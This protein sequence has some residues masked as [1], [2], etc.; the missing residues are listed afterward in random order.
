MSRRQ[1]L[2]VIAGAFAV[3]VFAAW[4]KGQDTSMHAW[5][6]QLRSHLGNLSAPW[7]LIAFFAG[8]RSTGTKRG[9]A[10]GLV[11]T[12]LAL[13]GFYVFT[14]FVI[15]LGTQSYVGDL[16][17]ELIA[18]QIYIEG[19]LVTGPLFGALGGWWVQRRPWPMTYVVAAVLIGEPL[20]LAIIGLFGTSVV[21][22]SLPLF[23]RAIPGWGLSFHDSKVRL[24]VYGVELTVGLALFVRSRNATRSR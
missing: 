3:G 15:D 24:A 20:V 12:V 2:L 16:R 13:L 8:T 22:G 19:G 11:A 14:T 1:L 4:A 6:A 21:S 10:Y 17:K 23:I 5:P 7:L 18:N 9:A